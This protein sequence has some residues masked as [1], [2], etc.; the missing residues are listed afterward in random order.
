MTHLCLLTI[1]W[2]LLY[3]SFLKLLHIIW[4]P[5]RGC[6]RHC[7][8]ILLSLPNNK[9]SCCILR[10]VGAFLQYYCRFCCHFYCCFP[11]SLTL[12][13]H[14]CHNGYIYLEEL[15]ILFVTFILPVVQWYNLIFRFILFPCFSS[16]QLC[17][18]KLTCLFLQIFKL[19]LFDVD[20]ARYSDWLVLFM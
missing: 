11:N 12:C 6:W 3:C 5:Q 4:L 14:N 1:L 2:D 16:V 20:V 17:L 15:S 7:L 19:H 10:Q 9:H 8:S 13:G 18:P